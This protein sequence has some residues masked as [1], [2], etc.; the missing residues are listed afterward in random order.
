MVKLIVA[1]AANRAIGKNNDLIWH[2]PADMRFFTQTTLNHIV[3]MGRKNWNSIPDK[4]R[5]LKD[6]L[7]V[8]VSRDTSFEDDGCVV[9]HSIEDAIEAYRHDERDTYI[10]GG[11]QI[12]KYVLEHDLVDQMLITKIDQSFD[13]DTFFPE[14]DE[15]LWQKE[16]IMEH[17][18]DEKNAYSFNVWKYEKEK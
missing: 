11:G 18:V 6:R 13:A 9:Y 8:V 4:Y 12:Y 10:I 2:L 7:N 1:I 16:C 5:P 3:V 15:S 14:F 17:P